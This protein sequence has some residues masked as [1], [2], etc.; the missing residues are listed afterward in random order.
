MSLSTPMTK[1][2]GVKHPIFLAGMN[3]SAGPNLAAAVT[4][5]GGV[6]VIGGVGMSPKYLREQ[7]E[8]L[9]EDL[10]DKSAPF[11]I[12]LL[13]PAVGGTAR[14]TNK[15]YTSGNLNELIDIVIESGAAV[16][17]SA[18]GVPPIEVVER[19]HK[20]GIVVMNMVGSPK[21]VPKALA[22][23]VDIIVAQGG[24]GGGH[25]GDCPT[26]ILIP[27]CVDAVKGHF[28]PLTGL[29]IQVVA[30]GGIHDSRGLALCLA[31]GAS[32][33]WV[34]TRFICAEEAGAPV[35]LQKEVISTDHGGTTRSL[36][37][38]GRPMR[39]KKT[40]L[41]MDW[42]ENR[43]P[44][45]RSLLSQGI[46]PIGFSAEAE[47]DLTASYPLIMGAVSAMIKDVQPAKQIVEEMV[48]G[49]VE[50]L[51]LASTYL[52]KAKL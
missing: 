16:F 8:E 46:I 21:H 39:V 37:F 45:L 23:G 18:V 35:S 22:V 10:I 34:G 20:A 3:V 25:T 29:P 5:A 47:E 12:D 44:E 38:S 52:V 24:E 43:Q 50:H 7:I 33:V 51:Q 27:A 32:S 31:A 28:S 17:I 42:E 13:L 1:L 48:R 40:A 30:A 41:V 26:A 6:G 11:G 49:A 2:F 9:K 14:K 19:L 36:I 4:N 15:D